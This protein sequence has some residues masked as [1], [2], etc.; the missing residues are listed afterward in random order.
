MFVLGCRL[1]TVVEHHKHFEELISVYYFTV[2]QK[3]PPKQNNFIL[4][5]IQII[6]N[7][8]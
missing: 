3:Q 6:V 1:I 4:G 7:L 2:L 8:Q 5:D